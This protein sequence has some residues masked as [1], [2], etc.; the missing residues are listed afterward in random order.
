MQRKKL[1]PVL[2]LA[3]GLACSEDAPIGN[4]E[5]G[6]MGAGRPDTTGASVEGGA[7]GVLGTTGQP[8][9]QDSTGAGARSMTGALRDSLH[10]GEATGIEQP[11]PDR[12]AN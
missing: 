6:G 8:A 10:D 9:H 11:Q 12:P 4:T 7:A 3:A 2:L 5:A 1:T